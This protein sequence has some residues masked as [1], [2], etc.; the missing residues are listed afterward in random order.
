MYFLVRPYNYEFSSAIQIDI[1]I[2]H[3]KLRFPTR[4]KYMA[5]VVI[6]KQW[7]SQGWA[8]ALPLKINNYS[9]IKQSNILIKSNTLL[10]Q[11]AD[12]IVPNLSILAMPLVIKYLL[13]KFICYLYI[14]DDGA[15]LDSTFRDFTY[16]PPDGFDRIMFE[17]SIL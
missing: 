14:V 11:S 7:H 17:K 15:I 10:K 3:S 1:Q 8:C 4:F 6:Y 13:S 9:L 2:C 12:L 5:L 16:P